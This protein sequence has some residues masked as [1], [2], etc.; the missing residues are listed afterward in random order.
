MFSKKNFPPQ[1]FVPYINFKK[2]LTTTKCIIHERRRK[3]IEPNINNFIYIG[4]VN[5]SDNRI[6]FV[7][8]QTSD[9]DICQFTKN[10]TS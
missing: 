3:K 2:I 1:L 5:K 9:I 6:V 7:W 4:K 10:P 8:L